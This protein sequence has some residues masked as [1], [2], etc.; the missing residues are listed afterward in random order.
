VVEGVEEEGVKKEN[1]S[2]KRFSHARCSVVSAVFMSSA[3]NKIYSQLIVRV[4]KLHNNLF[5]DFPIK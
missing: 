3:F 5:A 1:E 2:I 4:K